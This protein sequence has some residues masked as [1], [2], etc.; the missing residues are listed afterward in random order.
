MASSSKP[1]DYTVVQPNYYS[2]VT[3]GGDHYLCYFISYAPY[4]SAYPDIASSVFGF[5]IESSKKQ[6]QHK[7][8]DRRIAATIVEIVA[9]FLLSETDAVVYVCD[10]TDG[11][12]KARIKKFAGWFEF[13]THE[14]H[15]IFQITSHF[16]AGGVILYT[17][18]LF[19]RNNP[20]KTRFAEAFLE[21]NEAAGK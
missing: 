8:V 4:F 17:A 3:D 1:Y 12:G 11:K 10:P 15:K 14:S 16:D 7:G 21:L 13:F 19:N 9:T 2:F 18:L 6:I 5:N 20:R